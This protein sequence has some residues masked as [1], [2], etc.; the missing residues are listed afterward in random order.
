MPVL[1]AL[2]GSEGLGVLK[3]KYGT[4]LPRREVGCCSG[5]AGGVAKATGRRDRDAAGTADV[6]LD[7]G[8]DGR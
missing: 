5:I 7:L 4:E 2:A 8:I 3:A 1:A 6:R